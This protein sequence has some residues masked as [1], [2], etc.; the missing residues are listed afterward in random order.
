MAREL[1]NPDRHENPGVLAR[2]TTELRDEAKQV[3][4]SNGWTM[5]DFLVACL[6]L[7][8]RNPGPMLERL[9]EF[10][11]VPKKPGR[12]PKRAPKSSS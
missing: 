11:P 12:P 10:K 1:K 9:K 6:V 7:L 4:A 3:L 5:N 2:P 8:T